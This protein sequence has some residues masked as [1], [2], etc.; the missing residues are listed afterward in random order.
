[1]ALSN[2]FGPTL[3]SSTPTNPNPP[4]YQADDTLLFGISLAR[5]TPTQSFVFLSFGALFCAL[6]F[7]ALQEKVFM[8]EGTVHYLLI[9]VC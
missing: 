8:I 1:M 4:P 9:T 6:T 5:L 3:P 7:A 2:C